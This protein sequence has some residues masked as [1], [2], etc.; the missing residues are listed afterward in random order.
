[1][2]TQGL[3]RFAFSADLSALVRC[4][5]D[6]VFPPRLS[7]E[8]IGD[9]PLDIEVDLVLDGE[10][11]RTAQSSQ[12]VFDASPEGGAFRPQQFVFATRVRDLPRHA[13]FV[14]RLRTRATY[15]GGPSR[16]YRGILPLFSQRAVLRQGRHFLAMLEMDSLSEGASRA[17]SSSSS[18]SS[19][20]GLQEAPVGWE[21]HSNVTAIRQGGPELRKALELAQTVDLVDRRCL[22]QAMPGFEGSEESFAR[23]A[24]EALEA[25]G[26]VWTSVQ[27]P[28]LCH[29]VVFSEPRYDREMEVPSGVL[30]APLSEDVPM[31]SLLALDSADWMLQPF[32]LTGGKQELRVFKGFVDYDAQQEHPALLKSLRLARSSRASRI[33]DRDV[34]PNAD[35]LQRLNELIRR[36]RRQFSAEEKQLLFRFRWSLT[37]KPAALTKFLHAIDW[38]DFEER[39][40]AIELLGQWSEIDID[41]A[42]E[43]L[44]KDFRNT[45]E[46]RAHAVER[47]EKASDEEIRLFLLQLVQAL[48]YEVITQDSVLSPRGGATG[49]ASGTSGAPGRSGQGNGGSADDESPSAAGAAGAPEKT[50]DRSSLFRFLIRRAVR[51][52]T[53]ATPFYWYVVAETEDRERGA[54]FERVQKQFMD[55]LTD[56]ADGQAVRKMLEAQVVLRRSLLHTVQIP[57]AMKRDKFEKKVERFRQAL[58]ESSSEGTGPRLNLTGGLEEGIPLPVDPLITLLRIDPDKSFLLKSAM[59]PAVLSC[60]VRKTADKSPDAST[61][62]KRVIFKEGD[63]LRQDQLVLQL[64]I[65]MDSIL[66]KYGLDLQLTPYQVIALSLQDGI[67]EMV[68][69]SQN[70]SAVLKEHNHDIQQFFRTHHPLEGAANLRSGREGEAFGPGNSYGIKPEILENFVRSSAGYC[71]ITYILGIGDRHL[72]NL[73][74]TKDGRLFHIDFGF[75]LGKDPKPFPPPMRIC[76]EMVDGMGGSDSP[77]Y[78]SFKSKCCQAYKLL[79]RH[80]K[81]I[82]NLLYLMVDSGIKDLSGDPQ[83]ALLKVEQKF[84]PTMDDEQAEEHFLSLIEESVNALMP[85]MMERLHRVAVAI[86]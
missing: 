76:K 56:S 65:L 2:A 67:I 53:L 57:K 61:V 75:I 62:T 5:I 12:A 37:E 79:R 32:T 30:A 7:E 40:H 63:D 81:L 16:L 68:P 22:P 36:P 27:L 80:A 9:E 10:V 51:S 21:T 15:S 14:V 72:D 31:N 70:V 38:S 78:T 19:R 28:T 59:V 1:M 17:S 83:F 6:R 11:H 48:R 66:K 73:M 54:I 52:R 74:V 85:V 8:L 47:L 77:G 39:Q 18:R 41:D 34:R 23:Q 64:I 46:V 3:C 60:H 4:R 29:P 44:S 55:A 45:R 35:E 43:L 49:G 50:Q 69:D 20:E 71:V 26:F 24:Q 82:I 13:S 33:K 58:V 42:L 25:S 84:Q 86:S